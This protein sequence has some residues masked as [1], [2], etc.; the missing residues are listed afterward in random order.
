MTHNPR[1]GSCAQPRDMNEQP[2]QP[3][4]KARPPC[5]QR[6]RADSWQPPRGLVREGGGRGTGDGGGCVCTKPYLCTHM[7]LTITHTAVPG[8]WRTACQPQGAGNPQLLS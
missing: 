2:Q 5:G 7:W 8:I 3:G 1:S 6:S 4:H